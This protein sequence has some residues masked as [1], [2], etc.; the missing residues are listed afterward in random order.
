MSVSSPARTFGSTSS[1]TLSSWETV[2]T[3]T[4]SPA[5]AG[6]SVSDKAFACRA[7]VSSVAALL[8]GAALDAGAAPFAT[9]SEEVLACAAD[10][11]GIDDVASAVVSLTGA[12][13][14]STAITS[15][16]GRCGATS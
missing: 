7:A 8:T 1:D 12:A 13:F 6:A 16:G 3:A 10:I 14:G 9:A 5:T 11:S 2:E 15:T 4:D